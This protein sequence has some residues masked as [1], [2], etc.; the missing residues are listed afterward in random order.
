MV[1]T[2]IIRF[3]FLLF[4]IFI[5]FIGGCM[6]KD[7][8]YDNGKLRIKWGILRDKINLKLLNTKNF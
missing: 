2:M 1:K 8:N 3:F 7:K 6:K 5:S 4:K